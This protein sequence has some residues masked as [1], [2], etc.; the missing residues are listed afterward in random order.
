MD[1][2]SDL[3]FVAG[4]VARVGN[5]LF[6]E[7]DQLELDFFE[8]PVAKTNWSI[9]IIKDGHI[10]TIELK[11][12]PL[13]PTEVDIF[14]DGT[15]L[16]VQSRCLKDGNDVERNARRYNPNGQLVDAFT[17]GDGIQQVQIDESDTI[18][19]SY[20]DEGIFGNFGWDDPLGSDGVVAYTIHG[21]RLWG[22]SNFGI[23][24]CYALNVVSSQEVYFYYYDDFY[25]VKLN[26]K[27]DAVRYRV[28]RRH[29]TLQ[30][31][32]FDKTDL[33]GQID[34]NTFF[35]YRKHLQSYTQKKKIEFLDEKG[36][37]IIGPVFMR[38]S[39]LYIYGK[40]GIYKYQ[41]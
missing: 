21:K 11:N 3:N 26:K 16:I 39:F 8:R 19:V 4:Q 35:R 12:L 17:L 38:G 31:F 15:V 18:W 2:S 30:Q 29:H 13:I 28:N 23:V 9:K 6:I 33:I 7:S 24:D 20:F 41:S 34:G 10:E 1:Y 25:L 32:M 40:D 37:R 27:K 14:S 36:K 22:A 5:L